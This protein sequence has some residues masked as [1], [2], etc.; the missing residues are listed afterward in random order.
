MAHMQGLLAGPEPAEYVESFFFGRAFGTS[1]G[2]RIELFQ[3]WKPLEPPAPPVKHMCGTDWGA[4][5]LS[6]TNLDSRGK[7]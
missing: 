4:I 2:F 7:P 5:F 1:L 6:V 3:A